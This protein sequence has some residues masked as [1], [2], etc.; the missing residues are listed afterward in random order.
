MRKRK[1]ATET[2]LNIML[3]KKAHGAMLDIQDY[4]EETDG[5]FLNQEKTVNRLL[6]EYRNYLKKRG[7]LEPKQ[8]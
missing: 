5:K 6:I 1:Q 7:K 2:R 8:R 4:Y 3:L